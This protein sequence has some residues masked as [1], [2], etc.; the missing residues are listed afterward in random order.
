MGQVVPS[1]FKNLSVNFRTLENDKN[2]LD[3]LKK[4]Q[5]VNSNVSNI[6]QTILQ[7]NGAPYVLLSTNLIE[8]PIKLLIDTGA[9][10]SLIASDLVSSDC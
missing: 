5:N 1:E 9:S 10:L 8:R 3:L 7:E 4:L 2:V 6:R